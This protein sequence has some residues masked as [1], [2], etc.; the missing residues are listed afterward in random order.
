MI[1]GKKPDFQDFT[2][3]PEG[4][5]NGITYSWKYV[6]EN[7][8][9]NERAM[10]RIESIDCTIEDKSSDYVGQPYSV[11]IFHNISFGN[12]KKRSG[13]WMP[14][15]Q[16]LRETSRSLTISGTTSTQETSLGYV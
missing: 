13:N 4:R 16:K 12:H 2:P 7:N 11:G 10:L 6:G 5:Y 15:M 14:H 9:G 3:H 1:K 8:Y